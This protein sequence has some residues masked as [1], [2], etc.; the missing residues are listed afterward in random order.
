MTIPL[1]ELLLQ[2]WGLDLPIGG[3]DGRSRETPIVI[4]E[5]NPQKAAAAQVLI[6][7]SLGQ[8]RGIFWRKQARLLLGQDWPCVEQFEIKTVELQPKEQITQIENYYFDMSAAAKTGGPWRDTTIISHTT[9]S[10]LTIPFEIGWLHFMEKVDHEAVQPG[11]GVALAYGAPGITATVYI[12]DNLRKDIPNDMTAHWLQ[13]EFEDAAAGLV[14][15]NPTVQAWP[16]PPENGV[17]RARYYMVGE[18]AYEATVLWMTV[19]YGKIIKIRMTWTRDRFI[20]EVQDNFFKSVLR[21][22]KKI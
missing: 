11:L 8:G 10:K 5:T 21:G 2:D 7:R 4:T 3:G 15:V 22:L 9:E 14:M 17:Y 19:G 1:R 16:D 20:D 12:Y 6:L 18:E 13:A